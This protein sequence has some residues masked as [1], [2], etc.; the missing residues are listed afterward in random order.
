M[1]LHHRIMRDACKDVWFGLL[2][3][4]GGLLIMECQGP[5]RVVGAL[6]CFAGLIG[7]LYP[8]LKCVFGLVF[9]GKSRE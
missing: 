4:A 3:F 5:A 9:K 8:T 1:R 7:L 2:L 6:M